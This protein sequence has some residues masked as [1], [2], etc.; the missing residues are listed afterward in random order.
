MGQVLNENWELKRQLSDQVSNQQVDELI[1]EI[2]SI[3]GI[4][5]S[6]LLGAGSSGYLLV[7]GEPKVIYTLNQYD[8]LSFR[9]EE[10]GSTV[11]YNNS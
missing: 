6:K 5:G 9:L 11:F 4:Y 10:E 2:N 8:S 1:K 3:K 7:V